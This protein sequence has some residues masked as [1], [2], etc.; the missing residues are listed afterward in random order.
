M[1][2]IKNFDI[3]LFASS[4]FF[5]LLTFHEAS[6]KKTRGNHWWHFDAKTVI[7]RTPLK[8]IYCLTFDEASAT[9]TGRRPFMN[10]KYFPVPNIRPGS[11][12]FSD[13]I[14]M[15]SALF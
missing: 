2:A 11:L 4:C 3:L 1:K 9:G 5:C 12:I 6:V 13:Q 8:L 7:Q 10:L 14:P 15:G